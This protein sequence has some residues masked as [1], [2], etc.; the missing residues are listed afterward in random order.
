MMMPKVASPL[1]RSPLLI[2]GKG[3]GGEVRRLGSIFIYMFPAPER[4]PGYQGFFM[5]G[6]GGGGVGGRWAS[7]EKEV[8]GNAN[9]S[10]PSRN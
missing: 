9:E 1:L 6:G 3:G 2:L 8:G 10:S 4:K 5:C 7:L